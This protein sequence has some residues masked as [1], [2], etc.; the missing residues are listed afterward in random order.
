MSKVSRNE[1]TAQAMF[2]ASQDAALVIEACENKHHLTKVEALD[3]LAGAV[4]HYI[5]SDGYTD[6]TN[7]KMKL[8][9]FVQQLI[10]YVDDVLGIKLYQDEDYNGD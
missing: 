9:E 7:E 1:K 2:E 6:R 5:V 4:V 8:E 10:G 3:V